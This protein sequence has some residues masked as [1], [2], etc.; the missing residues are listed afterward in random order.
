VCLY[1]HQAI[2]CF[3]FRCVWSRRVFTSEF[4]CF[5]GPGHLLAL[6]PRTV[7]K[8]RVFV[9]APGYRLF[10]VSLCIES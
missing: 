9:F 4:F 1:S 3:V 7:G 2:V 10:C 8:G 6:P 5:E